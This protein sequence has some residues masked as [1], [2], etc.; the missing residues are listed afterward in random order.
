MEEKNGLIIVHTGNGKGKTTAALGLA[1]RAWGDGLRVLILQFIKGGWKYGEIETIKKLGA[2]DG[3]IE[4]RRLGKGFQ[5]NTDDKAEHIEAAKEALKEAGK[6]FE[7][8]N[9]DLII[10]DEINYAV[11]FELITVEDVKAL[12]AKRPAELHVVL[13]GRDAKEE[14]I[15]MADLVTEMKLIKHPYQKGIKAQKGIEF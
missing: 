11:K 1:M 6:A 12:L 7:S 9:Y 13:T 8:G 5:R 10:L 3:R 4:L 15:D 2:I 14:I